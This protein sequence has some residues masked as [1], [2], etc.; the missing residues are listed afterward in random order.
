MFDA[1]VVGK[2]AEDALKTLRLNHD[3]DEDE[4]VEAVWVECS[5]LG[6]GV[7]VSERVA[8]NMDLSFSS[9]NT[10]READPWR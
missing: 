3:G 9:L 1:G 4:L 2:G 6:P 7:T 10:F 5:E 8:E